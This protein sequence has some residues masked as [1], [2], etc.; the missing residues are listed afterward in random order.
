MCLWEKPELKNQFLCLLVCLFVCHLA[1]L[2]VRA[3]FFRRKK[4]NKR[5]KSKEHTIYLFDVFFSLFNRNSQNWLRLIGI[6]TQTS[7]PL[8]L[9]SSRFENSLK[10]SLGFDAVLDWRKHIGIK[11]LRSFF[12]FFS[13]FKL[14][15]SRNQLISS[16][17]ELLSEK[18]G[19]KI[20]FRNGFSCL[21]A[22]RS[23]FNKGF[24]R[25]TSRN[26]EIK[27]SVW[28]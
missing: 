21:K 20:K 1:F 9:S 13:F 18:N 11:M 19:K 26:F 17:V 22:S 14:H 27:M 3:A 24:V 25:K 15:F 6:V 28:I 2:C 7:F 12:Q 10:V 4:I 8:K 23:S 16:D 5:K